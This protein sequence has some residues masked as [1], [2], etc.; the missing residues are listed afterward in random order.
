MYMSRVPILLSVMM[1]AALLLTQDLRGQE[2]STA[3]TEAPLPRSLEFS[4]LSPFIHIY[5]I[6]YCQKLSDKDEIVGGVSYMNIRY[7]F[8]STHAPAIIAGYRRY[9]WKNLHAEYQVWPVYDSF[10][11]KIEKR[12]YRSFDLWNEFRLGYQF[13]FEVSAFPCFLS[14][15]WP[16][17]F[18]LYASNKPKSFR[19][20][21]KE[22]RFFYFPPLLF[23]GVRF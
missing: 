12:Y 15:Q 3:N 14:I 10:Y 6:Q 7:D 1:S 23:A 18:G 2:E 11:E 5:A 13:D 17:G 21:E 16:F 8:G 9:L 4:P 20:H 19:D 22:N